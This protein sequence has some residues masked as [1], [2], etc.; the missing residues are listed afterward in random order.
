MKDLLV[1]GANA[2]D[3]ELLRARLTRLGYRALAA[4]EPQQAQ[5]VLRVA[6]SRIGA[7]IVPSE[8]P[9]VNLRLALDA[10]RR[11]VPGGQIA[12]LGAGREP[13]LAGRNRMREAG[14]ALAAFDPI[15]LH[16]LRFQVNRALAGDAAMRARRRTT[17]RAPAD[18]PVGVKV[19]GREKKGRLY[20]VSASGAF[21]A[22]EQPSIVRTQVTLE[23]SLPGDRR[24]TASA[25][26]AM[27]NVPG[28]VMRRSL[29]FGMGVCFE[30]LTEAA[31]VALLVYAEE[32]LKNLTI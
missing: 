10:L 1:L 31:S 4:K 12:F 15:D 2:P 32:R 13:G 24:M 7:V 6:G 20:S 11:Q 30:Q 27:T 28:N 3:M 23:L 14:V 25:R 17:V 5:T 9:V 29:P 19:A 26:V 22:I 18:W 21:V 8:L 16:T